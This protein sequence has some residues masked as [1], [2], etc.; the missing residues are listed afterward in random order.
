MSILSNTKAD[1]LS[2]G[3]LFDQMRFGML[4]RERGDG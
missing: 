4:Y 2:T 1:N 3:Y